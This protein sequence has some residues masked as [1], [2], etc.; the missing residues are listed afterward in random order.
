MG[1][2]TARCPLFMRGQ[3]DRRPDDIVKTE[4]YE[5]FIRGRW[6]V[7]LALDDRPRVIRAWQ[8]LGVPVFDVQPGSGEF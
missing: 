3:G 8:A 5:A 7:L 6:D 1:E 4:I 2:W